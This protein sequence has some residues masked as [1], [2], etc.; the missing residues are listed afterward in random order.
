MTG[1]TRIGVPCAKPF[2]QSGQRAPSF[3]TTPDPMAFTAMIVLSV[4]GMIAVKYAVR[5]VSNEVRA[6]SIVAT[7][8]RRPSNV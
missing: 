7:I 3:L 6:S 4:M 2:N 8:L 5:T 1:T